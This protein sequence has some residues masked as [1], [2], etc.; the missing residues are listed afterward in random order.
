MAGSSQGTGGVG[1]YRLFDIWCHGSALGYGVG[2]CSRY[3]DQDG[4]SH[5]LNHISTQSDHFV[6]HHL[7]QM[8]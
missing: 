8:K 4:E 2:V 1:N 5:F 6:F 3:I 7:S